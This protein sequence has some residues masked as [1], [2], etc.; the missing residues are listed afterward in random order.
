MPKH[1][2][3]AERVIEELKPY[4]RG[5]I[6]VNVDVNDNRQFVDV[7]IS[8]SVRQLFL[9]KDQ[10]NRDKLQKMLGELDRLRKKYLIDVDWSYQQGIGVF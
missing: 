6:G 4:L 9:S 2:T 5:G 1:L 7:D 8:V 10:A 3:V